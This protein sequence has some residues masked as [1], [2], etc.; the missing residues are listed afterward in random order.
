M[1]IRVLFVDDHKRILKVAKSYIE[2]LDSDMEVVLVESGIQALE[3]IE[4]ESYDAIISDYQMPF[5][6]GIELLEQIRSHDEDI[7]FIMFTG[8]S[9]EEIAIKALNLG[10]THY[11]TKGGDP[12]SQ[13]AELIH[14]VRTS[15]GHNTAKKAL[16]DSVERYQAVFENALD[17]ICIADRET[18]EV[19]SANTRLCEMLSYTSEEIHSLTI[20]K[21]HPEDSLPQVIEAFEMQAAGMLELAE[22]LPVLRKDGSIFYADISASPIILDG[23]VY[24]LGFFRDI[25]QKLQAEN[26]LR[27]SEERYRLIV[28]STSD[29]IYTLDLEMTRTYLSPSVTKLRGYSYEESLSQSWEEVATPDSL[30]KM[31]EVYGSALYKIKNNESVDW[32]LIIEL[33]M[34]RSDGSTVWVETSTSPI[35]N[36]DG[37]IIGVV[38]IT[39]DISDRKEA[40]SAIR[41]SEKRYR[42]LFETTHDSIFLMSN[43]LFLECNER[44]LELFG[45]TREQIV[46]QTPYRY[47]PPTQPDGRDSREK[48]L[49]KIQ[50]AI[51]GPPQFFEWTHITYDGTPFDA[52]VSLSAIEFSGEILIQAI[53]RDIT[54]RKSADDALRTSEEMY[55]TLYENVPDGIV[56]MDS[57]GN[58]LMC[59]DKLLAM[60][61]YDRDEVLGTSFI[62][63]L[64]PDI[65]EIAQT[66]FRKSIESG[67]PLKEGF[68][69]TLI[70]KNGSVFHFHLNSSLT[71]VDGKIRGIQS[72][73]RDISERK[74]VEDEIRTQREELSRF[75]HSMVHDLRSNIHAIIGFAGLVKEHYIPDYVD[76]V[77]QLASK[78]EKLLTR[79]VAL[80][81]AGMVIGETTAEDLSQLFEEV[82]LTTLTES[83]YIEIEHLP[84]VLCD[85]EKMMQVVQNI[86]SNALEHGQAKTIKV[87]SVRNDENL[88]IL[89][90]NDGITIPSAQRD[91]IFSEGFT[92]KDHGGLGLNIVKRIVEAHDWEIRLDEGDPITFRITLPLK[93]VQKAQESY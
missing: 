21:L 3:C 48:A 10:A 68:E 54:K 85:R 34:Y 60:V 15:V 41:D 13:Y 39:R 12:K 25:T 30:E 69:G 11:V 79:S 70:R 23:R 2:R 45:C 64:H 92:T 53:V 59:N 22:R 73:I 51:D 24:Q 87:S 84:K 52:E 71:V 35:Q 32:P 81:E 67:T 47:S 4:S 18:H 56:G 91:Q 16:R 76:E 20:D 29:V 90:S 19:F 14:I 61:G 1:V 5:M 78:M 42:T 63:Y 86:I 62:D 44:T 57:E 80:A 49:E 83:T 93:D 28:E 33:E 37:E 40:E 58:I 77:I 82:A 72:Y 75:A 89:V 36:D 43:D 65:Q 38:G 31:L 9:R 66:T 88:Y 27:D 46:G 74:A 17:G 7:P 50:A 55:R 8:R 26:A 6:D